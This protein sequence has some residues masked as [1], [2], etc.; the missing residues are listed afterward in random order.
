MSSFLTYKNRIFVVSNQN[1][2]QKIEFMANKNLIRGQKSKFCS[3]NSQFDSKLNIVVIEIFS[4]L[5]NFDLDDNF[6]DMLVLENE[7]IV[8]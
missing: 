7:N 1:F 3:K 5:W 2:V 6:N 4:T 8:A